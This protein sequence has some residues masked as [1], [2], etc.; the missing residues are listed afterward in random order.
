MKRTP[1]LTSFLLP[2]LQDILFI[3][4][5]ISVFMLGFRM[6]NMDGDLGR[7]LTIGAYILDQR[8]IPTQDIFS[9]TMAGSPMVPHEWLSEVFFALAFRWLG[10]N[11]VVL[12][13]AFVI[14]LAISVIYRQ[15]Y[16]QSHMLV[17]SAILTILAAA[18][19]SLHWLVR[20]HLFTFLLLPFWV[21]GLERIRNG[22]M[23]AWWI[24][25]MMMWLWANLHGAFIAGF[26]VWL[27]ELAGFAWDRFFQNPEQDFAPG[28]LKYML[29]IGGS[30]ILASL[31]NPAGIHLWQTSIGYLQ[32]DYLVGHTMEYLSPDFHEISTWPFLLMLIAAILILGIRRNRI[33]AVH[34]FLVAAWAGMGLISARNIPLFAVISTPIL[35]GAASTW[36]KQEPRCIRFWS[37]ENKLRVVEKTLRGGLWPVAAVVILVVMVQSGLP[38]SSPNMPN[39]YDPKVFPVQAANWLEDHPQK[40][41][42]FN[43]FPW[44]GYLLYRS[45]PTTRV[46]IDGQTDFYGEALTRKYE[47]VLTLSDGWQDVLAE[48]H[49]QW[50]LMPTS[51]ELVQTLSTET[52]WKV[53]YQDETAAVLVRRNEN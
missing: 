27:I 20:P 53:E 23:R 15:A 46:F 13:A 39:A 44:G 11:G 28:Y 32:N 41:D 30:S 29:F 5:F 7:H 25:P 33:P 19:S 37:F 21:A 22:K 34:L 42:V 31:I 36:I 24:M 8:I 1:Q 50:I 35:A 3:G 6:I 43:Y 10:F 17:L 12:L 52:A 40:G 47:T 38:N 18:A 49:I 26:T 45:W 2:R 48:Y 14:A 4:I 9:H 51:S 16:A